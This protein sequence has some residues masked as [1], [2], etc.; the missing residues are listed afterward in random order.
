MQ[1]GNC[2]RA[3]GNPFFAVQSFR[4]A[5]A[6]KGSD[7]P[8]VLLN[9]ALRILP[10]HAGPYTL[11]LAISKA[12]ESVT[13]ATKIIKEQNELLKERVKQLHIIDRRVKES[14][15]RISDEYKNLQTAKDARN[16]PA[17]SHPS[18]I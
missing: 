14:A 15:R 1:L 8:D 2:W 3:L 9:L 17:A 10:Q 4:K 12:T 7:D 6:P 5:L 18:R 16:K 13:G 11:W